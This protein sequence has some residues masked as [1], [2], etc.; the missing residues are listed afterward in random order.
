MDPSPSNLLNRSSERFSQYF[1]LYFE[2]L[3]LKTK[4]VFI[5]WVVINT[6]KRSELFIGNYI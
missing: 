6:K 2:V 1:D 4:D 5:V 3:E